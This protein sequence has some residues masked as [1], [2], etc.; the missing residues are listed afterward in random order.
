MLK[1][2]TMPTLI[3]MF[4]TTIVRDESEAVT[5]PRICRMAMQRGYIVVPEACTT[6]VERWLDEQKVDYNATFYKEWRDLIN[7]TDQQLLYDQLMHYMST[8]GTDFSMA[9]GYI[10]NDNLRVDF[11]YSKLTPITAI[12]V[13]AMHNRCIDML[14][15]GIAL[16]EETVDALCDFI[17]NSGF[18][19]NP[20]DIK[21]REARTRYYAEKGTYPDDGAEIVRCLVYRATGSSLVI[22][23]KTTYDLIRSCSVHNRARMLLDLSHENRESL[24][25]VFNRF[26]PILL[27][28]KAPKAGPDGCTINAIINHIS[29][30]SKRLHKP[31][32]PSVLDNVAL[33]SALNVQEALNGV[34]TFR[35]LRLLNFCGLRLE[36]PQD[37]VYIVR[38]GKL[39]VK[40]SK[41]YTSS[42]TKR[43]DFDHFM[44]ISDI[45]LR[46]I[47]ND[48]RPKMKTGKV[49]MPKG[50]IIGLPTSEKSFVG[51]YPFGSGFELG[52]NNVFGVYWKNEWGARDIDFA[53]TDNFNNR[54]A[55]N[56][57]FR[58]DDLTVMHSGD[59]TNASPEAAECIYYKNRKEDSKTYLLSVDIY[60]GH[61]G[62]KYKFMFARYDGEPEFERGYMIDPNKIVISTEVQSVAKNTVVG[63]IRNGSVILMGLAYGNKKVSGGDYIPKLQ[64]AIYDRAD[65]T[66]TMDSLIRLAGFEIVGPDYEGEVDLDLV[67]IKRDSIIKFFTK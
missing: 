60:K 39:Y 13:E 67:N 33:Y 55:W 45:V 20:D 36:P 28:F 38:N 59:M 63:I 27:A 26:K 22:K 3:T 40:E 14:S 23:N 54:I 34:S 25:S 12:T 2:T 46:S 19:V 30:M 56:T 65:S 15:A 58:T 18:K 11:A 8:Y 62:A 17:I 66:Y 24:A 53:L 57:S 6:D 42:E 37:N 9:N 51:D 31:M 10:K 21:N 64:K 35:K 48:I 61:V 41:F 52:D 16:K 43:K 47:I 7:A 29:H 5:F 50:I 49:R 4:K 1:E 44:D 32:A